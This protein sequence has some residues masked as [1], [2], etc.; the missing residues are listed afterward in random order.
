MSSSVSKVNRCCDPR[1]QWFRNL[2][3]G[4]FLV[5]LVFRWIEIIKQMLALRVIHVGF[6][7]ECMWTARFYNI[8][9]ILKAA[10]VF[11]I[12]KYHFTG[13]SITVAKVQLSIGRSQ[14]QGQASSTTRKPLKYITSLV[15]EFPKDYAQPLGCPKYCDHFATCP[16]VR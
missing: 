16:K 8:C 6:K 1:E 2:I 11:Y 7:Y 9:T 12:S 5:F 13:K 3:V 14:T 10:P 15:S 4:F